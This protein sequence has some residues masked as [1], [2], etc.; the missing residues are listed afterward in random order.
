VLRLVFKVN[1]PIERA[2]KFYNEIVG[3]A[4]IN[5][6]IGPKAEMLKEPEALFARASSDSS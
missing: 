5:E 1:A 6:G 2:N 4:P 3:L